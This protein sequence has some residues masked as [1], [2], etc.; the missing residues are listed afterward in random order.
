MQAERHTGLSDISLVIGR[1]GL[2]K[3]MVSFNSGP[4]APTLFSF[5]PKMTFAARGE[6]VMPVVGSFRDCGISPCSDGEARGSFM[7]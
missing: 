2:T 4:C 3:L 5:V 6:S 7:L 1:V